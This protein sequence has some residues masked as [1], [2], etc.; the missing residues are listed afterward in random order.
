MS[1]DPLS[2]TAH[3]FVPEP[4]KLTEREIEQCEALAEVLYAMYMRK[5]VQ[6]SARSIDSILLSPRV[7][8][9]TPST[10]IN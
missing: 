10:A 7:F 6:K 9:S 3:P 5:T 4:T 8:S 1:S 2:E